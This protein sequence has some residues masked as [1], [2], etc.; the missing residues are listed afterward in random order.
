[1]QLSN[2]FLSIHHKLQPLMT[3]P[4]FFL[5]N[6]SF[7]PC[8]LQLKLLRNFRKSLTKAAQVFLKKTLMLNQM[9]LPQTTFWIMVMTV[10]ASFLPFGKQNKHFSSPFEDIKL[11]LFWHMSASRFSTDRFKFSSTPKVSLLPTCEVTVKSQVKNI[12]KAHSNPLKARFER[13]K[14]K[15]LH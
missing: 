14:S 1:M 5:K 4:S 2:I 12:Q 6:N 11:S 9:I 3:Y 13:Q 8:L 15:V 7:K 10:K